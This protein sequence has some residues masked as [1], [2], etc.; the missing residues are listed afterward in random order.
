MILFNILFI[1]FK[2]IDKEKYGKFNLDQLVEFL[3]QF[4]I[5]AS[6]DAVRALYSN[7][8]RSKSG[9]L[10]SD[11]EQWVKGTISLSQSSVSFYVSTIIFFFLNHTVFRLLLFG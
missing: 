4:E 2:T 8:D 6:T 10:Q 11:F 9:V 3:D 1:R 7:M 5:S